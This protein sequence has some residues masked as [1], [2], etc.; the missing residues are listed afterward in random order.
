MVVTAM[1]PKP[2]RLLLILIGLTAL[3][4]TSCS[5]S[6]IFM[7]TGTVT[8]VSDGDTIRLITPV[9]T[10]LLIRLYGIDA[11]ETQKIDASSG[12]VSKA[13][14]PYGDVSWDALEI[15]IMGQQV[16]VDAIVVDEQNR[17]VGT[18]WLG[19][20]N[21]NLEMVREGHAEAFIEYLKPPYRSKF[22]EAEKEAKSARRGIWSLK[23][24]ERP[25]NF[26][27]RLNISGW[28]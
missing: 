7:I 22:L 19:D 16:R 18:I 21:I 9:Q 2:R 1:L 3:L 12:R 10:K 15:K 6:I 8:E 14:Q 11:P 20:R 17:I 28:E 26:R 13:G 23:N 4:S 24:Y 25:R 27:K 5:Q